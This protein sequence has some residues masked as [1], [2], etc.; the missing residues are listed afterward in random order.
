MAFIKKPFK[1]LV[2]GGSAAESDAYIDL[3]ELTFEDEQPLGQA[4][5]H[6]VRVAEVYRYEDLGDL[7]THVYN[8]DMLLI[9][10]TALANDELAL[11]RVTADLKNVARDTGG[12]VAAVGKNWLLATPAGVKIDRNKIHPTM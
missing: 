9:D 11:K 8:G 12:D 4:A 6:W 5:Q 7:S 1:K 2:D 10:Y 3:G